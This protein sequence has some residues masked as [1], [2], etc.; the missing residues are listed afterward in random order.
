[1]TT[2]RLKLRID[3]LR[4]ESFETAAVGSARGTVRG[5]GLVAARCDTNAPDCDPITCGP[6]CIGACTSDGAG[7]AAARTDPVVVGSANPLCGT[8]SY[9][10]TC[11]F[12]TC[13]GCTS[14]DPEYC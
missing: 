2:S 10:E 1:M 6:S 4:V 7:V 13:A 11:I 12:Y 8:P 9:L 14:E 3:A 5:N